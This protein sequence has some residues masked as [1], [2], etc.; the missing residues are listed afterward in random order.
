V[1][2]PTEQ[3]PGDAATLHVH[4]PC[5]IDHMSRVRTR[6]RDDGHFTLSLH[7]GTL[8]ADR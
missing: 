6:D 1:R 2:S 8:A 4:A 3:E 5:S 7:S